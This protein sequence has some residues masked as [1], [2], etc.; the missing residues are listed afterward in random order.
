M[1]CFILLSHVINSILKTESKLM[2]N[3]A[4]FG[5]LNKEYSSMGLGEHEH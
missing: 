3:I 4:S 1:I 2:D 5:F